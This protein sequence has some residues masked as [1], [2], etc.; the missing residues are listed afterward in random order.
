MQALCPDA[1]EET[2][3]RSFLFVP[4]DS[5]RKLKKSQDCDADALILDLEDSVTPLERPR[6]RSLAKAFLAERGE[7]SVWVRINPLDTED[8]LPD[9]REIVPAAP[10]GIVLPKP[11]GAK[12]A[13]QLGKLLAVL[14]Q[15]NGIPEGQIRILPIA[16]ERPEALFHLHEYAGATP[17][18]AGLSWGAEDLGAALGASSNRDSAGN[19]LPP[20]ELARSLCLF[21]A[22]AA[23]VP[24]IDTIFA[25]FRNSDGLSRYAANARRDGFSGMLAIHPD[26]VDIINAAFTPDAAELERAQ[27]IVR[28]FSDHPETGVVGMDGEMLDRPHLL[29]AQK[30]I[31]MAGRSGPQK[32]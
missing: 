12:D 13:V 14:E 8:A 10:S 24:S 27:Q 30:I 28:L 6:A 2:V 5:E 26:Q 20:Y 29:Q 3:S 15:E 1:Q 16:T 11:G 23:G 7:T 19:W 4:A 22:A 17:R 25:D 9:L 21:A 18:L 32:T 31:A